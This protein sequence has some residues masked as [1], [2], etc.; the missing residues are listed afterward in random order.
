MQFTKNIIHLYSIYLYTYTIYCPPMPVMLCLQYT[1][2]YPEIQTMQE[3]Q[4]LLPL[5][6]D[7]PDTKTPPNSSNSAQSPWN[8]R[9][10]SQPSS[11]KAPPQLLWQH[12][13]AFNS[14]VGSGLPGRA[15]AQLFAVSQGDGMFR[16]RGGVACQIIGKRGSLSVLWL[17]WFKL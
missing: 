8:D 3:I 14:Q 9:R 13:T 2:I 5:P 15:A 10:T 12:C 11:I 7:L 6:L 1:T 16:Q 4:I 17:V